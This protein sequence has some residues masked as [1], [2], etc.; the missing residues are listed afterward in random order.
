MLWYGHGW[1]SKATVLEQRM[2]MGGSAHE[3][4]KSCLKE[5][6]EALGREG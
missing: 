1:L 4:A 6:H 2:C 5:M 3:Y